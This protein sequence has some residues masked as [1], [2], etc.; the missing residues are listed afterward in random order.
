MVNHVNEHHDKK[1]LQTKYSNLSLYIKSSNSKK[2]NRI[3]KS[4]MRRTL[5]KLNT[6]QLQTVFKNSE[7]LLQELCVKNHKMIKRFL[8]SKLM[9][10]NVLNLLQNKLLSKPLSGNLKYGFRG[11]SNKSAHD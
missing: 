6:V 1:E 3:V 10:V 2:R 5:Q 11:I 4:T 9:D 8:I 7:S